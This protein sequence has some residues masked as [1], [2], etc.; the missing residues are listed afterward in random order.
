MQLRITKE[1]SE[2]KPILYIDDNI[3]IHVYQE[4]KAI[5]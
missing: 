2:Y 4:L 5:I 3:N 1:R